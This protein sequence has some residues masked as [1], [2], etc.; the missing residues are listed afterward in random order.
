M[1][2]FLLVSTRP[3]DEAIEAEYEAFL[4][5]SGLE[6]SLLQQVRLDMMGL[7]DVD[8]TAYAGIF[9]GGSPYGTTTPDEK[10]SPTQ[11]RAEVELSH[12]LEDIV[13]AGTP[14]LATGYGAEVATVVRGGR[15]TTKWAE[16]PSIVEI[17]L[18]P[19]GMSDP[20]FEGFPE[21]FPTYVGHY[22]AAEDMPEGATL[23]A[24]SKG[25]PFQMMRLGEHFY[26]AQFNPEIDSDIIRQRLSIYED[27]GYPGTG[28]VESLIV[29][30]RSGPGEHQGGR[31][32]RNFVRM[33]S[34]RFSSAL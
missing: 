19:E 1:L 4:R 23:L 9:I 20:I 5:V 8:V 32:V 21:K 22:E 33:H 13:Q 6:K 15:V 30:A 25:C 34:E 18:T 7:P 31:I 26:A 24:S 2:P 28:D 14:C 17:T 3:E 11:K 12:L 27:A 16:D 29:R 10:K